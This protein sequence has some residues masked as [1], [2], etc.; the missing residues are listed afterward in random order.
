M[1]L[2]SLP[3]LIMFA[4][5]ACA[6]QRSAD[7]YA[8]RIDPATFQPQVDNPWWPLVP[9]TTYRY[10]ERK[11][12]ETTDVV[13]TVLPQR[14]TILGVDCVVV[15]D[16]ASRQGTVL[17]DTFDWYAQDKRGNVWYFGEDTKAYDDKGHV[18]TAGSWEAGVNGAQPGIVM[19]A[20]PAPGPAYRQEYLRGEAEDM[21]QVVA[22]N[23]AVSVPFGQFSPSVQ[24][25]EWSLLEAG[26]DRKWYARGIGFIRSQAEDGEVAELVAMSRV[27]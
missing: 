8:P 11:G 15:H 5:S 24:T 7:A 1:K 26:S 10:L 4:L 14:K 27:P 18:S 9:G 23:E 19:L 22:T 17:E 6:S 2:C 25:K 3:L 21:G 16:Q 13:V 20:D 12:N